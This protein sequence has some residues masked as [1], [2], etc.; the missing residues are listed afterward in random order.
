MVAAPGTW[1]NVPKLV[2]PDNPLIVPADIIRLPEARG[3]PAVTLTFKGVVEPTVKVPAAVDDALTAT[4]KCV[5]SGKLTMAFP[6]KPVPVKA[7]FAT[8]EVSNTKPEGKTQVRV[9]VCMSPAVPSVMVRLGKATEA[10]RTLL[11]EILADAKVVTEAL[12]VEL[13]LTC[14]LVAVVKPLD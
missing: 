3:V 9:P 5:A 4:L 10:P 14:E 2:E 11:V 13:I 6:A 12:E 1:V 7:T 8:E